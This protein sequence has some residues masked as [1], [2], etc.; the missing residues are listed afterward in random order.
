MNNNEENMLGYLYLE[1]GPKLII[2]MNDVFT[3]FTFQDKANWETLVMIANIFYNEYI[4]IFKDTKVSPIEE[5][6]GINTQFP[7]FKDPKS[8]NPKAP[9]TRI[10]SIDKVNYVDF[11]NKPHSSKPPIPTRST[12]YFGFA[13]SRGVDKQQSMMWLLN[14]A[15][16]TLLNGKTFSNYILMDEKDH[17]PHPNGANILY[18]DLKKLAK[19]ETKAG[20]LAGVLIA[21]SNDPKDEDVKIILHNLRQSFE[22]FKN[23]TEVIR[24]MTREEQL[25]AEGAAETEARLLPVIDEKDKQI[26]EKDEQLFEKDEQLVEKEEQLSEKD[27]RIEELEAGKEIEK[28]EIAKNLLEMGMAVDDVSKGTGLPTDLIEALEKELKNQE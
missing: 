25:K 26:S 24:I 21:V 12:E 28:I 22:E 14:G 20:E 4:K 6:I 3:N 23:N 1:T 15:I 16:P 27:K 11:E 10:E 17:H 8:T 13:L 19:M 7:F 9:D 5:V 2:P 18:V